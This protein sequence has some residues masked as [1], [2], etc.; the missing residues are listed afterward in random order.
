MTDKKATLSIDSSNPIEFP[1]YSPTLGKD[2]IDISQLG[3]NGYFC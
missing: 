1:I 2:V 3:S